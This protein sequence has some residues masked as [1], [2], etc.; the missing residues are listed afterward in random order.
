MRKLKN[1]DKTMH[2]GHIELYTEVH[3]FYLAKMESLLDIF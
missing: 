2:F 1:R 3:R